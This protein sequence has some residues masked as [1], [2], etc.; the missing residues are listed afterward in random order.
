MFSGVSGAKNR[1]RGVR[2]RCGP[3]SAHSRLHWLLVPPF[4]SFFFFVFT[5]FYFSFVPPLSRPG[6]LYKRGNLN[7]SWKRRWFVLRYQTLKYYKKS[8]DTKAKGFIS[9][10]AALLTPGTSDKMKRL[11]GFE[12]SSLKYTRVF[13]IHA[14]SAQEMAEWID[15]LQANIR[16][17]SQVIE[18]EKKQA[19]GSSA[20]GMGTAAALGMLDVNGGH[21][22]AG[23]PFSDTHLS[24]QS[25]KLR[26]S[27]FFCAHALPLLATP[28]PAPGTGELT[29]LPCA[30][31]FPPFVCRAAP[32][33]SPVQP[34]SRRWSWK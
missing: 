21:T 26:T 29:S 11:H 18:R 27:P 32:L 12:I 34:P 9:L 10:S 15:C 31:V 33:L 3:N 19:S 30:C 14:E 22:L 28:A 20:G 4:F 17:V 2:E 1:G 16:Y 6:W 23:H 7:S 13:I 25:K 5:L 24:L 8:G